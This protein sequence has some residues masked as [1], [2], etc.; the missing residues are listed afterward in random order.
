MQKCNF[1]RH[2]HFSVNLLYIFRTPFLQNTSGGM[3]Q[4]E[5]NALTF[6]CENVFSARTH[7]TL[8]NI[9]PFGVTSRHDC[10]REE[11]T[12]ISVSLQ[13]VLKLF[14]SSSEKN[15]KLQYYT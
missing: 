4:S 2:G 5:F 15:C 13:V 9:L 8:T 6:Q 14:R 7:F 1:N 11:T 10:P 3:P 12:E